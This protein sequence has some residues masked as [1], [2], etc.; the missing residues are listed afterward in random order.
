LPRTS[1]AAPVPPRQNPRDLR[2][3]E[4]D[5]IILWSFCCRIRT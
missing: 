1:S 4:G 3:R 2:C 5:I